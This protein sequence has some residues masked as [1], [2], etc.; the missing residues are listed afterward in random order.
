[1]SAPT[2]QRE[3]CGATDLDSVCSLAAGHEDDCPHYDAR[4][5]HEWADENG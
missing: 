5:D 1:M 3:L 2:V 4:T